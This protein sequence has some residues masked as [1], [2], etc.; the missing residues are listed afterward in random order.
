MSAEKLELKQINKHSPPE[1]SDRDSLSP[2]RHT[3]SMYCS[4]LVYKIIPYFI[5]TCNLV[6]NAFVLNHIM[7]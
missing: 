2:P 1:V 6:P 7:S 4:V 5:Y 3:V